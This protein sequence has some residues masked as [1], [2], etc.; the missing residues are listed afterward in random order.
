MSLPNVKSDTSSVNSEANSTSTAVSDGYLTDFVAFEGTFVNNG[1][2]L[3]SVVSQGN[4]AVR[5]LFELNPFDY[6]RIEPGAQVTIHLPDGSRTDGE[7]A[8]VD[9]RRDT[10]AQLYG[11]IR[12]RCMI[13]VVDYSPLRTTCVTMGNAEL[14]RWAEDDDKSKRPPWAKVR[15]INVAGISYDV[16]TALALKYG[17]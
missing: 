16:I 2:R 5:A 11:G 1:D 7:V 17:Q 3:A 15:W 14:A 10:A 9:V 13:E 4:K 8:G 6:G 12:A